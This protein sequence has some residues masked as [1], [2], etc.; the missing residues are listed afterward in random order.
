MPEPVIADTKP[1]ATELVEGKTYFFCTCGKSKT[2]PFCDGSHKG[3]DFMPHKFTAEK[4]GTAYLCMCKK[5]G[6][7]PFCDGTHNS[8]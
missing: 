6:N 4:T 8:I 7:V 3:S 2:Q 5:T 1:L